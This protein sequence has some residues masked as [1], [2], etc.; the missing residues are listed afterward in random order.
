MDQGAL[1]E[2]EI[3]EGKRLIDHLVEEGVPVT[4]AAWLKE[5][6]SGRWYLYI[7]TPL[8]TEEG[9]TRPAYR[10]VYAAL[11]QAS[12]PPRIHPLSI[13]VVAPSSPVGKTVQELQGRPPLR[14]NDAR[15]G[16]VPVDGAFV[17][18]PPAAPAR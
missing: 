17:Y 7:A 10:S 9:G 15:F 5:A 13:K 4:G 16:N 1:V 18:P 14:Y 6:E 2:T 8:V 12:E 3:Q 11:R